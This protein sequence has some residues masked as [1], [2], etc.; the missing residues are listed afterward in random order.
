M[1]S[2]TRGLILT[3]ILLTGSLSAHANLLVNGDFEDQPNWGNGASGNSGYTLFTNSDD[4]PG[5]T[6]SSGYGVTVHNTNSYPTISGNY[7]VNMDAEGHNQHNASFYQNFATVDGAIYDFSYD[8]SIW[9]SNSAIALEV[10]IIDTLTSSSIYNSF[11]N[12]NDSRGSDTETTTFIGT[13]NSFQLL[14][15][16][17]PESGVNDNT[18]MVDNFVVSQANT[19]PNA[20][21]LLL[22]GIGFL[23]LFVSKRK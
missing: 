21:T 12:G 16:E 20:P 23:G 17:N 5:W 7:S 19:V 6:I 8:W 11:I 18:F 13:G 22:F 2:I 1:K 15:H 3:G 4:M 14:I 9:L 10:S